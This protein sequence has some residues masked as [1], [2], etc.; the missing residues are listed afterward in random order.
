MAMTI[1]NGSSLAL[2]LVLSTLVT[3][4]CNAAAA[5]PLADQTIFNVMDFDAKPNSE[6]I[7]T[8]AFMKAWRAACDFTGH[9]RVFVPPGVYT[10]G[11]IIF[12]GPCKG[13][14]S[15]ILEIAGTLKAV[16]DVSEYSN[17]AWIS[18]ESINGVIITGG[19]TLDAQGQSVW[20]FNDCKTNPNCVHLP[21]TLH[22]N[23]IRN[24]KV[25]RLKL[26]NSMGFHLHIT[27][28]YL[29]RFHG[30]TIDA[31]EDSPNTDGIHISKSNT[32]KLSRSVIR[33][34]DDC[35]SFGQGTNNVTVNKVTCGPGHGISVGSLGKLAG[36]L[37]VRG[38]I[39][40][41]C[42]LRGTTNGIRIKTYA[43]ENANR[44]LGMMFSDIVMENVKNPIIIDQSYGDK[45][46]DSLSQV[47][48]S[49]VVY[50]NIRGTTSSEIPVQLLCSSKLPCQNVRL[51]NINLKHIANTPITS[52]CQNV[53]V[54]YTGI[55]IPSPC[56][57]PSS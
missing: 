20:Q 56:H 27:N 43:G 13:T 51:T 32:I 23:D 52:Q 37:E 54:G 5:V 49:D 12:A 47:K 45:S 19:G 7:S 33:T 30:L 24:G 3:C 9:A 42:T 36:E 46:T 55:Q 15:I 14:H 17:F 38:L 31:P 44:A 39:V 50:Q 57:G 48:I 10:L 11:E 4:K 6:L 25:M 8:Q 41:N 16:P 1:I 40:K 2:I 28:S 29:V 34:G 26:I 22:F 21:A 53:N 35:V 18:F